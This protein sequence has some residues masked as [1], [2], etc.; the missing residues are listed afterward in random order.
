MKLNNLLP[1]IG[2]NEFLLENE[3][4]FETLSLCADTLDVPACVFI[5]DAKYIE[6]IP[7]N[8]TMI[9]ASDKVEKTLL[10]GSYGLC[11]VPNP[12]IVFFKLHNYLSQREGYMRRK[13]KTEIGANCRISPMSSIAE[14]N[15]KIGN[16]VVIEEFVVIRENTVIGDRGIIRAGSIIGGQG[17]EFKRDGF[18]IIAVEHCGGVI[19]GDDVEIQYNNCIDRALYPWDDTVIGSMTKTDNLTYIAH[20]VKI[21]SGVLIA[22]GSSITG[23]T[24]IKGNSWIGTGA[25]VSNG[26]TIGENARVSIGSVV[27]KNVP[28]NQ[29][30]TGNFA[31][32]HDKFMENLKISFRGLRGL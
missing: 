29:T 31:I 18:G 30:V 25:T 24:R 9:I 32:P 22:A 27:T 16:G 12:R 1:E 10:Q 11:F 6:S 13:V 23:R 20:G 21:E 26:L 14:Y 5:E 7:P 8:A 17:F 15:V 2:C 28:D 19:I 3:R 4:S